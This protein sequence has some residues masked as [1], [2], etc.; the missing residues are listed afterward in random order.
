MK[1]RPIVLCILDGYGLSNRVDGNAVKLAN[2][3][4][5]DDLM[6]IYPTTKIKASGMPVGLP[7][8]QMG[9]SEVGH[10]NIGAGRTVYQSLTLINKAVEDRSFYKN[11]E[12]LKAINNVKENNSKLHIWGLLSNGGV[13]S[14]NEHIY[15]LLKLAKQEGVEK[16]YVHAF[17]D[18]RDVAPDSGV[19]FVKELADKIEEIGVGEIATV[20]G[21]YYAM[22]RDKRF[23]RVE[24]AF[25]AI[26]N[27]KGES[28][29]CPVQYVKDS[30]AKETYDEFV[31]PGYNKN[32]DGQ[33]CDN[34]SVIFAN[35]QTR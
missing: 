10:L 19:D 5:I 30:Y 13:H 28:F 33:V 31:I 16:V 2:T 24:L 9:N 14:S 1:K 18:G 23:D 17:L 12:F 4:N 29:E 32:V 6:M 7:D 35:L 27:H 3:P 22:D 20:S 15:S 8:G 21:R 11:E 25:D 26:V 34:D